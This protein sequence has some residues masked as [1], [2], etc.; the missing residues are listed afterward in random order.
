[1]PEP[2]ASDR[3]KLNKCHPDI[4]LVGLVVARHWP[5]VVAS[6]Y[7][8][9]E[10]QN[11]L[12]RDGKSKLKYPESMHNKTDD[13]GNP[14]SRA[15]DIYPVVPGEGVPWGNEKYFYFFGG[16]VLATAA[17]MGIDLRWGGNW[18]ENYNLDDQ[19]FNDLGHFELAGE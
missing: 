1:M 7:R 12:Y 15:M 6:T 5:C 10:E 11:Q 18:S 13:E 19:S 2:S 17:Q 3:Q 16:Y 14:Q 4:R 8:G 9:K